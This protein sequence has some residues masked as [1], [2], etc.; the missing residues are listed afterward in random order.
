[1]GIGSCCS[2]GKKTLG[3]SILFSDMSNPN[4][5]EIKNI[6]QSKKVCTNDNGSDNS[7]QK[8]YKYPTQ[9]YIQFINKKFKKNNNKRM[10]KEEYE[11]EDESDN[12]S[13]LIYREGI[14]DSQIRF[15]KY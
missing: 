12:R 5:P 2:C 3:T 10:I 8:K 6:N 7:S 1:M 9:S 14:I 15:P 4:N 11:E 13:N